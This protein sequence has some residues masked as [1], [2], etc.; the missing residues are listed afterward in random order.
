VDSFY[1]A[2]RPPVVFEAERWL[3]GIAL[4]KAQQQ[5]KNKLDQEEGFH[6]LLD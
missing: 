3:L 2:R 4:R 6:Q 1:I 5:Q